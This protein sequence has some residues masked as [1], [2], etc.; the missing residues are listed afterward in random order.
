VFTGIK[1]IYSPM[2]LT[3]TCQTAK[4]APATAEVAPDSEIED[5]KAMTPEDA[6][7]SLRGHLIFYPLEFLS[8]EVLKPDALSAEGALPDSMWQ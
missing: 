6:V 4:P 3:C 2:F 5:I 1:E 7:Q 8:E